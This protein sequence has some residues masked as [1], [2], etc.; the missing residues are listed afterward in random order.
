L[1]NETEIIKIISSKINSLL[2]P[3]KIVKIKEQKIKNEPVPDLII[4]TKYKNKEKLL[5]VKIKSIGEPRYVERAISQLKLYTNDITN[6]YP[7]VAS[8]YLSETSR[9]ICKKLNVGYIDLTGNIFIDLP[10]IH[11]EKESEKAKIAEKKRQKNLFSPI[12]TRIIRTLLVYP[13]SD[14]SIKSLSNKTGASLGYTHRVVERLLDE[15]ILYRDNNFR[16]KLND[17]KKLLED[18]RENYSYKQNIICPLYTFEKNKDSF[19]KKLLHISKS[20]NLKY[21][22]TLHSGA[23][24]IAPY[25]R[26]TEIHF[27]ID[28]S[29]ETW[30][31]KLDLRPVES[32]ANV[33]LLKPYD[34]GV[35]QDIQ[36]IN[37]LKIVSNIQLYLD[38]YNYPKRGREQSEFLREKKLKF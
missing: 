26:F 20:N 6:S 31:E 8:S 18:W 30:K 33:Y 23:H 1:F 5:I 28:S 19:F 13:G 29:L 10:Y 36:T 2:S 24:L 12:S 4:K 17:P 15:K 16:L 32:G 3:I 11:I 27:Y 25:V 38:L 37:E 21:A 9:E 7:I 22:L 35:F 14:W 34:I